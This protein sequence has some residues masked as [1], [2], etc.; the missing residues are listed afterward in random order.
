VLAATESLDIGR[1]LLELF[2]IL[3]AAKVF[4][5]LADRVEVPAVI[6][7]ILAGILLGPSVSGLVESSDV[8]FVLAEIGV[9][10]LL[11]QVG[12]ETDPAELG[13]V[14]RAALSVAVLGV[15]APFVT[16]AATGIALGEGTETAIFLGAALTA[17]SVG[18]TARVFGDLRAL[19]TTEARIVLGAAVA[20]DVLG[21]VIL[22]VVTKVVV[23]GSV[24]AGTVASTVALALAFLAVT[25]LIGVRLV[26]RGFDAIDRRARS[27]ATVVVA[28]VALALGFAVLADAAQLAPIIGAFMAGLALG[29]T[30]QHERIERDV[31]SLG[32]VFVPIFFVFIGLE[33]DL[34]A[35][36]EPSV[37]A[38]AAVLSVVAVVGKLL[39]ATGAWGTRADRLAI[40]LAMIPRGE[41][42]LIFATLGL[43]T[44][45]LDAELYAALLAVVLV[46]T[47]MTP[48]LLRARMARAER[49][50]EAPAG[51]VPVEPVE[52]WLVHD[53]AELSL[54]AHTPPG[55][56]LRVALRLA[57]RIPGERP[58]GAT[59]EWFGTHHDVPL[60]WTPTDTTL[61]TGLLRR[62]EP[63]VWR[64]LALTGVLDRSLPE[65]ADELHRRRNDPAELDPLRALR[66]PTVERL[67]GLDRASDEVLLLAALL[68]D[69]SS[70][71]STRAGLA[72]RLAPE[73]EA[74]E[75]VATAE[76]ADLLSASARDPD[77]FDRGR[78]TRLAAHLATPD[79]ARRAH[80]VA[81]AAHDP[82]GPPWQL[83]ALDELH[84]LVQEVFAHPDLVGDGAGALAQARLAAALELAADGDVAERLR[85]TPPAYLLSHEPVV[86]ARQARLIEPAPGPRGVR[87]EVSPSS[88]PGLWH[89]DVGAK[90]RRGLLARVSGALAGAGYAIRSAEAVTWADGAALDTFVV[91]SVVRPGAGDLLRAIE[92]ALHSPIPRGTATGIDTVLFDDHAL[93]WHTQV[94]VEA[95]DRVGLLRDLSAVLAAAGAEV[96][97]ARVTTEDGRATLR[98]AVSDRHGRKLGATARDK[99]GARLAPARAAAAH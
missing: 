58:S 5:E 16:G 43:R 90:D 40:G 20:D 19:A 46:T 8:V 63:A 26:P 69:V 49:R 70:D 76:G 14:G 86:L 65:V 74:H 4:A 45:V 11:L 59:L 91:E 18:I 99:L 39:A 72:R 27:G 48:P 56:A 29:R 80:A 81:A 24:S 13:R 89:I 62:S 28:G 36:A 21:L 2:L 66:F 32:N 38:V 42:G 79:R 68:V 71:P 44:G 52:G 95:T 61:L 73:H 94:T 6:G 25:A 82:A 1:V 88:S 93:P 22:T 77:A 9:L 84:D 7:E 47:V 15:A 10:V 57:A 97:E 17:T 85:H 87:V 3:V 23:D 34:G 50:S 64:F 53:G 33:T 60:V 78:I 51:P 41:V 55:A 12:L 30:R 98:F 67:D 54:S 37:L 92:R 96:H 31:T 83:E 35:F 75:I